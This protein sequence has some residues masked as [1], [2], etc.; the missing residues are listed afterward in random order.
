VPISVAGAYN[1]EEASG[2]SRLDCPLVPAPPLPI[3]KSRSPQKEPPQA[4]TTGKPLRVITGHVPS[5][6]VCE[7]TTLRGLQCIRYQATVGEHQ[8]CSDDA[9]W[10]DLVRILKT[11]EFSGCV[12]CPPQATLCDKVRQP[13]VID[14]YDN[15][16]MS[17]WNEVHVRREA[18]AAVRCAVFWPHVTAQGRPALLL[19][20]SPRPDSAVISLPPEFVKLHCFRVLPGNVESSPYGALNRCKSALCKILSLLMP[21]NYPDAPGHGVG[22]LL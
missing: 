5:S 17:V 12:L 20:H 9:Y 8:N 18:L 14:I 21:A 11:Q 10:D 3:N 16:T 22:S 4:I 15:K 7:I 1:H 19:V 6:L 13:S 2:N